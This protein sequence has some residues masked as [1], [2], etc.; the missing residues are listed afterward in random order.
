MNMFF[1][2]VV[3]TNKL[4][5]FILIMKIKFRSLTLCITILS[6]RPVP[7]TMFFVLFLGLVKQ[8]APPVSYPHEFQCS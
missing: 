5:F 8:P 7:N 3:M 6:T 1:R 4:V 2:S